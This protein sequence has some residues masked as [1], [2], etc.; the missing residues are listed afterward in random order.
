MLDPNNIEQQILES[1]RIP[2]N[3]LC[4]ANAG[5][6]SPDFAPEDYEMGFEGRLTVKQLTPLSR[7]QSGATRLHLINL[8]LLF[9][10]K[11]DPN[12]L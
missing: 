8:T 2:A 5:L 6:S 9:Y 12:Y 1:K 3:E 11:K 10:P 4:R 7:E